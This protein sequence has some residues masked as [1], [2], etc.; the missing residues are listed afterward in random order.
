MIKR[1]KVIIVCLTV[2]IFVCMTVLAFYCIH[3]KDV[4]EQERPDI[5]L[6]LCNTDTPRMTTMLKDIVHHAEEDGKS[7]KWISADSSLKKQVKDIA[8]LLLSN[9]EYLVIIPVKTQGL[10]VILEEVDTSKTKIIML[11]RTIDNF[12]NIEIMTYIGTDALW[13]GAECAKMLADYFDG[14]PAQILEIEGEKGSSTNKLHGMGFRNQLRVYSNLDIIDV[15]EGEG[16]RSIAQSNV[17]NYFR[18]EGKK[19]DA[20]YANTDEEGMGALA[21]LEKLGMAG[22]I[23]IVSVNGVQDVKKAM[24]AGVYYGCVEATPYLGTALFEVINQKEI[25]SAA[26]PEVILDGQI[27]TQDNAEHM[28]GY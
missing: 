5:V 6:S 26:Y 17:Y 7:L 1:N 2:L 23:P 22:K 19:A 21:A 28:Q 3:E 4:K 14:K 13:E 12:N 24:L 9:P 10:E 27:F 18:N 16:D 8:E 11:D 20:I 25:E 15:V